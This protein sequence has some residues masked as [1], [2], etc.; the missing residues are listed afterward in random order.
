MAGIVFF[1][2][3]ETIANALIN[4]LAWWKHQRQEPVIRAPNYWA[5]A[6]VSQRILVD[7]CHICPFLHLHQNHSESTS[8]RR[9]LVESM[10]RLTPRC[11]A[12]DQICCCAEKHRNTSQGMGRQLGDLQQ[13]ASWWRKI[14]YLY[15]LMLNIDF[16]TIMATQIGPATSTVDTSTWLEF[17]TM[18]SCIAWGQDQPGAHLLLNFHGGSY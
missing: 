2:L 9:N 13:A 18:C 16:R 17:T 10:T 15:K 5:R 12:S 3:P 1:R 14:L 6:T 7:Q 8:R 4:F 11:L